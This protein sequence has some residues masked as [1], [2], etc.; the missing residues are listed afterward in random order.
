MSLVCQR[1]WCEIQQ[2]QQKCVV[3]VVH[4]FYRVFY[5]VK[6]EFST[7]STCVSSLSYHFITCF[8]RVKK[9]LSPFLSYVFISKLSLS[10]SVMSL[11]FIFSIP[12]SIFH[13]C[14]QN[15]LT[16]ER[17]PRK[18]TIEAQRKHNPSKVLSKKRLS[19]N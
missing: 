11:L 16:F 7:F 2:F 1:F 3:P 10:Q 12:H 15:V 9:I 13:P 5:R 18:D 6:N 17:Y 8:H 4:P 14:C 19:S